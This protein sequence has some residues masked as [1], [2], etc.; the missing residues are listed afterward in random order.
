MCHYFSNILR[1]YLFGGYYNIA[2]AYGSFDLFAI[3]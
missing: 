3:G 1:I 2:V